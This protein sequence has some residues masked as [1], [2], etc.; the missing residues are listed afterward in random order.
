[1]RYA[2]LRGRIR[3]KYG[4]LAKFSKDLGISYTSLVQRLGGKIEFKT[5]EIMKAC[6]LL[7][8]DYADA[9]KYFFNQKV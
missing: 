7:E 9:H 2:K 1:M 5:S 8:I 4:T 6:D 3:E